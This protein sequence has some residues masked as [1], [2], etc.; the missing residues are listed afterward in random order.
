MSDLEMVQL[1]G[2]TVSLSDLAGI[3]FANIKE[4]R[5]FAFPVGI[6]VWQ[7]SAEPEPPKLKK[8]GEGPAIVFNLKCLNVIEMSEKA[9]LE[10]KPEDL[11]GQVHRETFFLSSLED[12]GFVKAFLSDIGVPAQ[13]G[14]VPQLLTASVDVKFAGAITHTPNRKDK[15]LPPYVN[16]NRAKGKIIPYVQKAA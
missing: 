10:F 2:E 4:K 16:I 6:F 7:V 12:L 14:G 9:K 3:D 5:A 15:D 8:L 1:G 13:K 11:V